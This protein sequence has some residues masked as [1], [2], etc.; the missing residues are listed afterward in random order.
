MARAI[1]DRCGF[2]YDL[3]DLR[4]E[5]TGLRVCD[6]DWDPKPRELTRPRIRP[7]G[8]PLRGARPEPEPVFADP[9]NPITAAD[10]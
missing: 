5:W 10:L 6:A 9:N 1:C 8:L 2:E 4:R 7:E 3:T